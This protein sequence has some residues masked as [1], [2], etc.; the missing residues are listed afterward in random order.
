MPLPGGWSAVLISVLGFR[1][2]IYGANAF[3]VGWVEVRNPTEVRFKPGLVFSRYSCWVL[4]RATQ[5]TE[6]MPFF[7]GWVEERNPT[8]S[9]KQKGLATLSS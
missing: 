2:G 3:F 5:P 7:V 6:P 4:L 8:K 1:G 9:R